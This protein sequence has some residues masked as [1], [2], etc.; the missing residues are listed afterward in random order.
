MRNCYVLK[1]VVQYDLHCEVKAQNQF[2]GNT[3]WE[4]EVDEIRPGLYPMAGKNIKSLILSIQRKDW[5]DPGH[6]DLSEK[7]RSDTTG[8]RS[9][10]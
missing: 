8:D 9:R 10:D 3:M 4:T 7:I 2:Q 5:V 6:V 1:L